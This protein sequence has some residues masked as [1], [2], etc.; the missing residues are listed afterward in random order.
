MTTTAIIF[1][2]IGIPLVLYVIYE[3]VKVTR[4]GELS[5]EELILLIENFG[6]GYVSTEKMIAMSKIP[7]REEETP[8][9]VAAYKAWE[10][11]RDAKRAE[12]KKKLGFVETE[13]PMC[14]CK[15]LTRRVRDDHILAE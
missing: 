14:E 12:E 2:V 7:P 10:E 8:E 6:H 13:C 3:V 1:L 4:Q 11:K 5:T 9:E 15:F